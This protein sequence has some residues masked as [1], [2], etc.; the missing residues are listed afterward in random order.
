MCRRFKQEFLAF[1]YCFSCTLFVKTSMAQL[2]DRA[3]NKTGPAFIA[4]AI[5]LIELCTLSFY[6]V[7]FPY[8]HD[9]STAS[10]WKKVLTAVEF[11]FTLYM[12]YCIHFHY[13]MA[14]T[15]HPGTMESKQSPRDS[16][17]SLLSEEEESS[18]RQTLLEMEESD[19]G[20]RTMLKTC[21]KCHLPKPERA[22]HC[23]VCN[24]CTMRFDHHCPWIHNCVGHFNHR[25]FV[26]F[27]TYLVVSAAYFTAFG[28]QPFMVS[29]DLM[30]DEW[31]YY[32][33]RP[34][35]AFA[36]ILAICMGLAIGGLCLWH[37]YLVLTAQTTVEFY[38]NYYDKQ[39]A[40]RQGEVFVNMYDFG[41]KENLRRFFNVC[42]K[43]PWYTVFYPI[44]IPPR[45]SGISYEKCDA[46]Y[47]LSR[48][49]QL[50]HIEM[51]YEGH[52][53]DDKDI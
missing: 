40:R 36:A 10:L 17:V 6:L 15:T 43:F 3:I 23:S 18:L 26:L 41:F 44:P 38:N 34:L 14:I 27:M 37:Y 8:A 29:L 21:K 11:V 53:I 51:R 7:V 49:R 46:F 4:I 13:Y 28:W 16:S 9:W 47:M 25:Y 1:Y 50:D 2:F 20:N 31:P 35:M 52:E 39:Q 30:N 22:H 45:G 32:Y 12:V 24:K 33:P 19:A 5:I 42:D 48:S